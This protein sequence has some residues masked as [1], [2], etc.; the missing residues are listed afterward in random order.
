MSGL[1]NFHI[2]ARH[3]QFL[4][5]G[6]N[7]RVSPQILAFFNVKFVRGGFKVAGNS[8]VTLD[9]KQTTRPKMDKAGIRT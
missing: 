5:A 6:E 1:K 3:T 2:Q 4:A 8:N 7:R 9:V